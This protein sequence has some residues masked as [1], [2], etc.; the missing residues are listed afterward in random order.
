MEMAGFED[1]KV[2]KIDGKKEAL[3]GGDAKSAFG[4]IR[5]FHTV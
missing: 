3:S 2:L 4:Q 5:Q 1:V